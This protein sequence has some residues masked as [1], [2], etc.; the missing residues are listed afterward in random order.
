MDE[1]MKKTVMSKPGYI[2]DPESHNIYYKIP[3][4]KDYTIRHDGAICY[5]S[6]YICTD[7]IVNLSDAIFTNLDEARKFL[8]FFGCESSDDVNYP[9]VFYMGGISEDNK[10]FADLTNYAYEEDV[11]LPNNIIITSE[12]RAKDGIC[13]Y[14]PQIMK[15]C[16]FNLSEIDEQKT[17]IGTSGSVILKEIEQLPDCYFITGGLNRKL[18]QFK[19]VQSTL[20]K[21]N[22]VLKWKVS[23][24]TPEHVKD[25]TDIQFNT[26]DQVVFALNLYGAKDVMTYNEEFTYSHPSYGG[27][28]TFTRHYIRYFDK[29]DKEVILLCRDNVISDKETVIDVCEIV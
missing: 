18:I 1:F 23:T 6:N 12:A 17:T 25:V 2:V 26:V 13:L 3:G 24:L 19:T 5:M 21:T 20:A 16:A 29:D 15:Q 27:E 9:D 28:R 22:K 10:V 4:V 11:M 14:R 8:E 7:I